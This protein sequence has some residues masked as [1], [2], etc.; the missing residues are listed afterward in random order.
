MQG[1]VG[2]NHLQHQT[3]SNHM[4]LDYVFR[5]LWL[6]M[7]VVLILSLVVF[8]CEGTKSVFELEISLTGYCMASNV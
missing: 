7:D 8:P 6:H 5:T 4:E 2:Q 3:R 1:A